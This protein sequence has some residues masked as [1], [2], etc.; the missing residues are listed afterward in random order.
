MS[1]LIGVFVDL[2]DFSC[3]EFKIIEST[4]TIDYLFRP[5]CTYQCSGYSTIA[6]YPCD[7][8]LGESLVPTTEQSR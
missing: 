6:Q 2:S 4:N 5:R 7:C 8:H 1:S 3:V